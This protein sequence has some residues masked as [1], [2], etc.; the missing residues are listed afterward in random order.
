[1]RSGLVLAIAL[2]GCIP[3][4]KTY[5]T[6][7]GRAVRVVDAKGSIPEAKV[8]VVRVEHPYS[9]EVETR[10]FTADENGEVKLVEEKTVKKVMPLMMHGVP[11]YSFRAC[12][13]ATG[14]ASV[15]KEWWDDGATT[16][17]L[18]L[19]RGSRP[20]TPSKDPLDEKLRLEGIEEKDGAWIVDL[21]TTAEPKLEKESVLSDRDS[22][23]VV[24]E[25]LFRSPPESKIRR[26][27][28]RTS[29]DGSAWKYGDLIEL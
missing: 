5:V 11:Q 17:E 3:V 10:S 16:I 18:K 27:Q 28:V 7:P 4:K 29:G 26:L 25:I 9:R 24:R 12:A 23:L 14:H 19:A 20:C 6:W 22:K 8:Q 1:M 15:T 21:A 13:E 2:A